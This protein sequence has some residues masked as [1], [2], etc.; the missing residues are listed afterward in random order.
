MSEELE[1]CGFV[2]KCMSSPQSYA[3][4]FG[5]WGKPTTKQIA[6]KAMSELEAARAKDV[7]AHERNIPKIE[8]N[9]AIR[10]RI[11]AIMKEAGVPDSYSEKD[12]KSRAM[13]PKSIRRD[14][15]YIGDMGR[16]V[17]IDDSFDRATQTYNSL[18]SRYDEYAKQAE[19]DDAK[20]K[21]AE[22]HEAAAAL[23]KRRNDLKLAEIILR[24]GL[25]ETVEWDDVLDALR[26]KDQR[27]DLA[28][29]MSQTRGDWSEG[30]YRVSD[31]LS[32]FIV[33]TPEDAAI[34]TDVLSCFNDD[35]DGRVFRDTSWNYSRLFSEASDQQLSKDVQTAMGNVR[36]F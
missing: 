25:A 22:E 21:A 23:E 30:Y 34:Q 36:S 35:I 27:L 13:Y 31:A 4:S 19:A 7:E 9:K 33:S 29:A 11:I 17:K 3:S 2:G 1:M 16:N 20:R 12:P 28:V 10:D 8:A 14:A 32:R 15:G 6:S 18:K 5:S 24:Y 26:Q